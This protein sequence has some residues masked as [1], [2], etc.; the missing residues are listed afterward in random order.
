MGNSSNLREEISAYLGA[1][2]TEILDNF[3]KEDWDYFDHLKI[4]TKVSY[5][6]KG[7]K[8]K[9]K[10]FEAYFLFLCA[11]NKPLYKNYLIA[12][13]AKIISSPADSEDEDEVGIDRELVILY[14]HN[15]QMGVGN[16]VGWII[17]TVLNKVANRN[18]QRMTT[19][20]LS[21]R[22][23][24]PF[25]DSE[26]LKAIN[27]GG[28]TSVIEAKNAAKTVSENHSQG[29]DEGTS[30]ALGAVDTRDFE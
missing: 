15:V 26:E 13:Y 9:L 18:R 10:K 12:D 27:L 29:S 1:E 19:L 22:D 5:F 4:D 30:A 3:K 28:A 7:S 8:E 17:T 20:I 21:E 23:F 25:Q 2:R 24:V 6:V 16:T 14:M 11:Y